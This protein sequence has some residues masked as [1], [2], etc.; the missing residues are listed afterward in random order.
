[1]RSREKE[2]FRR[3]G[4]ASLVQEGKDPAQGFGVVFPWGEEKA[5]LWG[6]RPHLLGKL[7]A[8]L[9]RFAGSFPELLGA[10]G[11]KLTQGGQAYR[12]LRAEEVTFGGRRLWE[13]A[14]LER[15]EDDGGN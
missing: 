2:W 1:M 11:G 9:Y 14:L 8:P 12:V 4:R 5:D 6:E 13:Q 15:W 3:A 10:R 7:A